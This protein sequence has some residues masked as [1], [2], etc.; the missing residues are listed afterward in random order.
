MDEVGARVEG[1]GAEV[2]ALPIK[3]LAGCEF[4]ARQQSAVRLTRNS[5]CSYNSWSSLPT[6]PATPA[7]TTAISPA[8]NYPAAHS[9][10]RA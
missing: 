3:L 7:T 9:A 4:Y 6:A 10:S 2:A 5:R 1:P 8:E